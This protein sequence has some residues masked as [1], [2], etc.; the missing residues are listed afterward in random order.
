MTPLLTYQGLLRH[1][2]GSSSLPTEFINAAKLAPNPAYHEWI[3]VDQRIVLL[4]HA[5]LTEE[6]FSEIVGLSTAR[7]IWVALKRAYRNSSMERIQ[8]VRD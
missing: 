3:S 1:V 5:S 4:L 7:T 8:T 2:D 6:A